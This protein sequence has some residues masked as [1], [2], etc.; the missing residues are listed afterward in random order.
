MIIELDAGHLF[1]TDTTPSSYLATGSDGA[2]LQ[3]IASTTGSFA[4]PSADS[5]TGDDPNEMVV[6]NLAMN[7]FS[8]PDETDNAFDVTLTGNFGPGDALMLRWFPNISLD[9]QQAGMTPSLGTIY[10]QFEGSDAD[11]GLGWIIPENGAND[12]GNGGLFFLTTSS[13]GDHPDS[14]S[15]AN[16]TVVSV[17]EPGTIFSFASGAIIFCGLGLRKPK[18]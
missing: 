1:A 13:G 6:A 4:A 8:G 18:S 12:T 15:L 5:F 14:G 16:L 3:L 7:D 17:P 11:N 2:L 9:Q 10:G